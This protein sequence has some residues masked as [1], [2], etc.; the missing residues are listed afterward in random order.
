[1]FITSGQKA[2]EIRSRINYAARMRDVASTSSRRKD[3]GSIVWQWQ[4]STRVPTVE[5]CHQPYLTNIP[6][7]DL[8]I[9]FGPRVLVCALWRFH[10]MEST[11]E[12]AKGRRA[13]GVSIRDV[14]NS[15]GDAHSMRSGWTPQVSMHYRWT[16]WRTTSLCV[17]Q[18]TRHCRLEKVYY[19]IELWNEKNGLSFKRSLW[20]F[21][22]SPNNL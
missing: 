3:T 17:L 18:S 15:T 7:Q 11:S 16:K 5:L 19:G 8:E 13:W 14:V 22:Y 9:L 12:L 21:W 6:S 10:R 2:E 4:Y 1:M 20:R